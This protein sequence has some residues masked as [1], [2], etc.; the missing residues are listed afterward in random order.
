MVDSL[1]NGWT[2]VMGIVRETVSTFRWAKKETSMLEWFKST[3]AVQVSFLRMSPILNADDV[4]KRSPEFQVLDRFAGTWDFV[5]TH[6]PTGGTATT[7][8]TSEIR[9][10]S[11]AGRFIHF[12]NP[13]LGQFNQPEF[14]LLGHA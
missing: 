10:W 14:H 13:Q 5:V 1:P 4:P 8:K 2:V 9:R 6:K 11:L 3:S 7:G 12:Q